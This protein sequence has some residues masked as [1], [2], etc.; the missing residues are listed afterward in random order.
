MVDYHTDEAIA[1]RKADW[2]YSAAHKPACVR[3]AELT[4]PVAGAP[5]DIRVEYYLFPDVHD[6]MVL[7]HNDPNNPLVHASQF[8]QRVRK[9]KRFPVTFE[10]AP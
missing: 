9:A 8:H 6:D 7:D 3:E 1:D 2:L 10:D 4:A 5:R